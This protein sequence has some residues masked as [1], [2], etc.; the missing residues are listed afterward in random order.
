MK[1]F[2]LIFCILLVT[3]THVCAQFSEPGDLD[4]S[5]NFGG[6]PHSFLSINDPF[7]GLGSSFRVNSIVLLP[8]GK[9]LIAGLFSLYN[10]A[11]RNRIACLNSDGSLNSSFNPGSG[12]NSTIMTMALQYDGKVI[13]A[14]S[15]TSF[16]GVLRNRIAR[17]N[18][19]GSLDSTFNPGSGANNRIDAVIFQPDGKLVIGGDFT[20]FDGTPINRI[21]RL[22]SDGRLDTTF[23]SGLGANI[24]VQ[25]IVHISDS[26]KYIIGGLFISFN[27]KTVRRL[28]RL[29]EF[30]VLDTTFNSGIGFD[31]G[32]SVTAF[33][34]DGK[35]IIGGSFTNY[36]GI[37]RNRIAR[38]N[39]DG[40]LDMAFDPGSG[41]NNAIQTLAIQSDGKIVIGGVFLNYNGVT[42]NRIARINTNG[43]LDTTFSPV[44]G[45]HGPVYALAVQSDSKLI[46]AGEFNMFNS[47]LCNNVTRINTNGSLDNNFNPTVGA[48]SVINSITTQSDG[49]VLIGGAFTLYNG[50]RSNRVA[51]LNTD[52]SLDFT[53]NPD[54]GA[55]SAVSCLSLQSSGRVLIGG[56]FT[57]FNGSPR[58]RIAQLNVDGSLDNTFNAGVGANNVVRA[59]LTQPDG[60]ILIGGLFTSVS[61][62]PLN[63]I[64]RLNTNGTLDF[65]FNPG[66]GFNGPVYSMVLRPDGKILVAGQFT[67]FNNTFRRYIARLNPNGSLDT[68]FNPESSVSGGVFNNTYIQVISLQPDGKVLIGGNFSSYISKSRNHIARINQDGTLDETFDPGVGTDVFV[69]T[70]LLQSDGLIMIGG[71]FSNYDGY[72]R[73]RVARLNTNGSLDF[74]FFPGNGINSFVN[75]IIPSSDGNV[76]IVGDF[77]HYNGIQR[78]RIAKVFTSSKSVGF[79]DAEHEKISDWS[80]FPI[81]FNSELVIKTNKGF[82]YEII[83]CIGVV[84]L[85]GSAQNNETTCITYNL[86]SGVY[87]VK[88]TYDGKTSTRKIVKE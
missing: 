85:S 48:N 64:A 14:G 78:P 19:D 75:G 47:R 29:N 30:G 82:N 34:E 76:F 20:M 40:S 35:I 24:R 62:V 27:G 22:N 16:N 32:V 8:D 63:R 10:G 86:P 74:T 67:S 5:F 56:D 88:V 33:Q 60:K 69:S 26:N 45:A 39:W 13:I 23:N 9:M 4:T 42:R 46:I 84:R 15:F 80:V 54:T 57:R 83:D 68:T 21:A 77:T 36:N 18:G 73:N 52:G 65:S 55:N 72:P 59:I 2:F 31:F 81:P 12:A 25:S 70:I 3:M 58:N 49:K 66:N 44:I 71:D 28:A 7:P 79:T 61:G 87:F 50:F 6:V 37:F 1:G 53:F 17:I 38:L 51:R 43:T 11:S 41:A